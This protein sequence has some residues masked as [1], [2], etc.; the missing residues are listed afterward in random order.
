MEQRGS[1]DAPARPTS[2]VLGMSR[3]T[4]RFGA[5]AVAAIM[6][7]TY[8]LIG[9]GVL[10]VGGSDSAR[11]FLWVFGALAGGAFLLGAIL[12]VT[13]DR[14]WVW[15]AGLLFQVFVYW[16]YVDVSKTRTPP[17]ET[18]GITL[19]IVQLPLLVALG[20]LA[21]KGSRLAAR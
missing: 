20:Y 12:L 8:F 3:R 13:V 6:A 14:R 4:I 16:A 21:I 7:A 5:A 18:W 10:N 19:R 17:F 2:D 11:A 1:E 15:V 9:L